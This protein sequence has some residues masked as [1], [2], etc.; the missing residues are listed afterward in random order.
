MTPTP[1]LAALALLL[2]S[3]LVSLADPP[4]P[5]MGTWKLNEAKSKLSP[6]AVKNTKVVY[7]PQDKVM[8]QI[9]T[10]GVDKDG[11]AIRSVWT[12]KFDERDYLVSLDEMVDTRS[13]KQI[14]ANTLEFI[15]KKESQV[16]ATGRVVLSADGKIRT[17]T[18]TG[19]D[20]D[21]KKFENISVYE[22][23]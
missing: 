11:N 3:A 8:I 16:I 21:G 22:K 14:D 1:L 18:T 9:M 5:W 17:V 10:E 23:Q 15:A 19:T 12:G 4:N 2:T 7:S 13:Y 6:G 20:K